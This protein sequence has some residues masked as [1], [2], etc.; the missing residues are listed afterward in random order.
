MQKL[1]AITGTLASLNSPE[2]SPI[3][4]YYRNNTSHIQ[5]VRISNIASWYFERVVFPGEQ[6]LFDALP[7]AE[8]EIYTSTTVGTI[9]ATKILCPRLQV[10]E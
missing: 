2:I 10:E 9:L 7:E 6:L 3:L 8:L 5:T 4:C 1:S